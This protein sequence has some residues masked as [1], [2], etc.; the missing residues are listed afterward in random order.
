M[1]FRSTCSF[2]SLVLASLA[3]YA[4]NAPPRFAIESIH[5]EILTNYIAPLGDGLSAAQG[6][7]FINWGSVQT[8]PPVNGTNVYVNFPSN[9]WWAAFLNELDQTE[10]TLFCTLELGATDWAMERNTNILVQKPQTGEQEAG[11]VRIKPEYLGSWSNFVQHLLA[12]TPQITHLQIENEPDNVWVDVPGY[13]E[14]LQV[15][16]DAVQAF[17]STNAGRDVQVLAAGYFLGRLID[18]PAHVINEIIEIYPDTLSYQYLADNFPGV[19]S[20]NLSLWARKLQLVVGVLS[21]EDPSNP[22]FD[23][24]SVHHDLGNTYNTAAD[25]VNWYK[26]VMARSIYGAYNRPMWVDDM[27]SNQFVGGDND[28][29]SPEEQALFDGLATNDA[30]TIATFNRQQPA[31]LVRKSVG[32]FAGGFERIS[33]SKDVDKP[34]FFMPMWRYCGLFYTNNIPKPSYYTTRIM[35]EKLDGFTNAV[36]IAQ[37]NTNYYVYRF[38]FDARPDV[39]VAWSETGSGSIDV[40][41]HVAATNLRV[42]PIVT[43]TTA[44]GEPV[45]PPIGTTPANVVSLVSDPVFLEPI[46]ILTVTGAV[47]ATRSYDGTT[48]A[49]ITGATLS[50]VFGD[51]DVTLAHATTGVFVQAA[52]GSNITV[53]TAMTLAGAD[54]DNYALMQPGLTGDITA[55]EV[56]IMVTKVYDGSAAI[57]AGQCF[58]EGVVAGENITI[59]VLDGFYNAGPSPAIGGLV[60]VTNGPVLSGTSNPTNYFARTPVSGDISHPQIVPEAWV[61]GSGDFILAIPEGYV[62]LDVEGADS[63]VLTENDYDW[64]PMA[65]N[66]DYELGDGFIRILAVE[67]PMLLVRIRLGPE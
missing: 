51:D 31:R 62:L 30:A 17:N 1:K 52:A 26:S 47:V 27:A 12:I 44:G 61:D 3:V 13:I 25:L 9:S 49:Q 28:P 24:L 40:S 43:N 2:V 23:I 14:T 4:S 32:F 18:S 63:G 45:W 66:V 19:S 37:A 57:D 6:I 55:R 41:A 58:L 39:F 5:P 15:A 35:V 8:N 67:H 59:N 53:I 11:L 54:A 21:Q 48:S 38:D 36:K 60:T 10:R 56:I 34:D 42:T 65:L 29:L 7:A 22:S 20:N 33:I 64:Q 46:T 16:Y 50:G